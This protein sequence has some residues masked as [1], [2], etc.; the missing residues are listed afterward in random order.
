MA[1]E[2]PVQEG[3]LVR[4]YTISTGTEAILDSVIR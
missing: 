1:K 4:R 3:K 2:E